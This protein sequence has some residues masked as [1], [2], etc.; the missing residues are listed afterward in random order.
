M[1]HLDP[2]DFAERALDEDASLLTAA[3]TRHLRR[4]PVCAKQLE[5]FRRVVRAARSIT[6][7]DVALPP[8]RRVW[9]ALI[10]D[11]TTAPPDSELPHTREETPAAVGGRSSPGQRAGRRRAVAAAAA[12]ACLV[13]GASAGSAVTWWEMRPPA[14]PVAE[15]DGHP[16]TS[17]QAGDA[18]GT[19][20]VIRNGDEGSRMR[21]TVQGLPSTKGYYEVWLMDR[22]HKK[23]IPLG[24][25]GS[26]G[27]SRSSTLALPEGVNT[28]IYA[29]L[30][31]S[32]QP[33]DGSTAHSGNSVVR[34]P[35][36]TAA[37]D[38]T[39]GA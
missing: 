3:Q 23:L 19:V 13:L 27:G 35:L 39:A 25:L 5:A 36:P 18:R 7:D 12:A 9:E 4:C 11:V 38:G 15:P 33:Y 37:A 22:T 6:A 20:Q 30:D 17:P 28:D 14:G 31:I 1:R 16:L 34:G 10:T 24:T 21:V 32:V 2:A 8:P 26:G 29:L